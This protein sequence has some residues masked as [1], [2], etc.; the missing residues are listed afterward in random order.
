M[1][2]VNRDYWKQNYQQE[3]RDQRFYRTDLCLLAQ[4]FIRIMWRATD[5]QRTRCGG[6]LEVR[7]YYLQD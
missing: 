1:A 4:K 7:S 5:D 6:D 3:Q 2:G